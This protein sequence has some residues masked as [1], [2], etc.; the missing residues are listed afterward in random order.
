V[1][2]GLSVDLSWSQGINFGDVVIGG[3]SQTN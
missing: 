1:T 2:L 3:N